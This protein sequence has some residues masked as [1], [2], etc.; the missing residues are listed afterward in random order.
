[1]KKLCLGLFLVSFLIGPICAA[2]DYRSLVPPPV[3]S[4]GFTVK[5]LDLAAQKAVVRDAAGKEAIVLKHQKSGPWA[6]MAVLQDGPKTLA[7]FEDIEEGKG[8]L[9]YMDAAGIVATLTKTME[10]TSYPESTLYNGHKAEDAVNNRKDILGEEILAQPGDPTF[11]KVVPLLTPLRAPTF[12]GTRYSIDKPTFDY[13]AFSDE[14]YVDV[15]KVFPEIAAARKKFDVYEG[16]VGGWLPVPRF[17]FPAGEK[18]AWDVV[19][20][21]EEN[22]AKFWTQPL[23]FRILLIENGQVKEAHHFYHHLPIAPRGEPVAQDFYAALL[24]VDRE[25]KKALVPGMK[26]DVPERVIDD[27]SKHALAVEMI[28]RV[29][30]HPKYGYPPLGGINKFGGYGY[31]N[32]DTFQDVFN[33]SVITFSEWGLFDIA[34]GYIDDYFTETV[35]DDGSI[36]S[37]GPE[38]GQYGLMLA[39]VA[40]YYSYTRDDKTI[41]KHLTRLRG[42]VKMFTDLRAESKKLPP[43]DPAYGIIRG[44][45]EHDSCLKEKPYDLIQPFF[46]NSADASRGFADLGAV[47]A[48]VGKKAGNKALA[49]EGA[50]MIREAGEMKKDLYAAIQKTMKK[51]AAPPA[52]PATAGDKTNVFQGRVHA[53][54]MQSGLMTKDMAAAIARFGTG[55]GRK[56]IGRGGFLYYGFGFGILQHDW[57][58]EYILSYYSILAHGYTPG[59]WISVE[60]AAVDMSRYAPYAT[61]SQLNIPVLTKWMLVFEDPNDPILWLAKATPRGWLENGKKIAVSGA[62]TR[63]GTVGY[64]LKSELAAN[65]VSGTVDLPAAGSQA[66]VR[67]RVRVP[68]EKKIKSVRVNG[69]PWTAFDAAQ[70]VVI[71]GA[72]LRGRISLE[73]GF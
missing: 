43:D 30:N 55:S 66:D 63:F 10:R 58:R 38:T 31:S 13:G 21:A 27:F 52:M 71:L 72:A 6:L 62:P 20:F 1:M 25:W 61:P 32:V 46:S 37:R 22:P 64:E 3:R 36:D 49:D 67:L 8:S 33:N 73:I 47:F 44:W 40:K 51:D 26:I 2:T 41:L 15:G 9:V 16:I 18:R 60:S 29:G 50:A 39:A 7:V 57:V 70:D 28:T 59:T 34:R 35:R 14:I 12:V 24:K 65:K 69:K 48:E 19:I 68:G 45:S 5:S 42:I 17:V 56:L 4:P 11:E 23:W 54:M 53:E